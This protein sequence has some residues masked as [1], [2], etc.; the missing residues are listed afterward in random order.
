M[1]FATAAAAMALLSGCAVAVPLRPLA[2][3]SQYGRDGHLACSADRKCSNA[4]TEHRLA[5]RSTH[6]LQD[7]KVTSQ[8]DPPSFILNSADQDAVR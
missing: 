3:S 4:S 5:Y 7:S 1:K 8:E 6:S 2:T